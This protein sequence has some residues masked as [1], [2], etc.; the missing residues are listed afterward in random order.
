M[1]NQEMDQ[2]EQTADGDAETVVSQGKLG[3]TAVKSPDMRKHVT[4]KPAPQAKQ[5]SQ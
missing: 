1:D 2:P 3:D 4:E 5:T